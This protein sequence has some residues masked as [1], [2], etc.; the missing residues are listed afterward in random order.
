MRVCLAEFKKIRDLR[1]S[2]SNTQTTIQQEN[3]R[4]RNGYEVAARAKF[5]SSFNAVASLFSLSAAFYIA[6]R[7]L[8][9]AAVCG[10]VACVCAV[11]SDLT[12]EWATK[13]IAEENAR[14]ASAANRNNSVKLG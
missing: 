11:L 6:N 12:L 3:E 1:M 2:D 5:L 10:T 13:S 14:R 7:S 8:P 9:M 4:Q